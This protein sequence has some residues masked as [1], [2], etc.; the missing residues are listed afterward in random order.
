MFPVLQKDIKLF[1]RDRRSLILVIL[2]PVIIMFILGHV[3]KG[4]TKED[5]LKNIGLILCND[6]INFNLP[7]YFK[8]RTIEDCRNSAPMLVD[9]GKARGALIVPKNFSSNLIEGRGSTLTLYLDNSKPQTAFALATAIEAFVNALNENISTTF[10]KEAWQNLRELNAK[11]RFVANNLESTKDS[12]ELIKKKITNISNVIE[13]INI[14]KTYEYLDTAN[15]SISTIKS[16]LNI[17]TNLTF[18]LTNDNSTKEIAFYTDKVLAELGELE[19]ILAN[20]SRVIE[21]FYTVNC[22]ISSEI[23]RGLNNTIRDFKI[24]NSYLIGRNSDIKKTIIVIKN[25]SIDFSN[26]LQIFSNLTANLSS[27]ISDNLTFLDYSISLLYAQID[28][29]QEIKNEI[30]G[31]VNELEE[32]VINFTN[33]VIKLQGDLNRTSILLDTYTS[34]RPENIVRAVSINKTDSFMGKN[35]LHFIMPGI[36]MIVLMLITLLISSSNIVSEKASATMLRNIMAPM[37][38]I[39]FL[40]QKLMFLIALCFIQIFL[41]LLVLMYFGV[42]FPLAFGLIFVLFIASLTFVSIGLFIGSITKTENTSLLSS[43]VIVIPMIFMSGVFFP[44]ES[45]PRAMNVIGNYL[46]LSLAIREVEN[47]VIYNI[48]MDAFVL[49]LFG[50]SVVSFFVASGLIKKANL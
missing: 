43:L 28:K 24:S 25:S 36:M 49:A 22:N 21:D 23:C 50:L 31:Q 29:L 18:N 38:L 45:M 10:I 3:F 41:M 1:L 5:Y 6:D 4:T 42:F 17:T 2:T 30:S 11:I 7:A 27:A 48:Q 8:I 9:K 39:Y 12:A 20:S 15:N 16:N 34:R 37:P 47:I 32:L 13:V 46:P 35:N 14:T 40:L 26:R 44:F 19:K 33:Q